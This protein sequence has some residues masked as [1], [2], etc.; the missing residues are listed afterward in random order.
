MYLDKHDFNLLRNV[1]CLVEGDGREAVRLVEN[2]RQ[3]GSE[4]GSLR[5]MPSELCRGALI[6]FF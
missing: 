1:G 3:E 4:Q 2:G 5:I 6:F